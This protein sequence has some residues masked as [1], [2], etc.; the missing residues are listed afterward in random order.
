MPEAIIKEIERS[1][2]G[3][4]SVVWPAPRD[5]FVI[6]HNVVEG[7]RAKPGDVLFRIADHLG[8]LGAGRCRRA[9]S[10]RDRGGPDGNGD[11]AR[12]IRTGLSPAKSR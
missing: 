4:L 9:R 3:S 1:K 5:G 12:A 6:E 8:R 11:A 7:M 10:R 2:Q